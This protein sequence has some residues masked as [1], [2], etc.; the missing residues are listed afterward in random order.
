MRLCSQGDDDSFIVI[1]VKAAQ[2]K[3]ASIIIIIIIIAFHG[4]HFIRHLGICNPICVKFLQLMFGVIAH[5]SVKKRS[6]YINEWLSY[7]QL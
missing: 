1:R 4:R 2:Y 6:P 7:S 3:Y 5:N